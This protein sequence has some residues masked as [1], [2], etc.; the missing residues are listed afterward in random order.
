MMIRQK[1]NM[2][3]RYITCMDSMNFVCEYCTKCFFFK[4]YDF[5]RDLLKENDFNKNFTFNVS[6]II[7]TLYLFRIIFKLSRAL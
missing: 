4:Q 2:Q 6:L 1:F 5:F 3:M 7:P